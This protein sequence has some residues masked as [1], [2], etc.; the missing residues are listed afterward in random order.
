MTSFSTIKKRF[1]ELSS[2]DQEKL[3]KDIYSFSKDVRLFLE[4][5]LIGGTTIA[6][7]YTRQME[8]ETVGK[9]YRT[10]IPGVPNGKTVNAIITKAKK[11][12]VNIYTLMSIEQ[13][14]YRGFIEF[15]NEFGGG[16]ESFDDQACKH[17]EAYLK[18]L[19]DGQITTEERTKRYQELKNY[20]LAKDNIFTDSLDGVYESATGISIG[21]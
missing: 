14:A 2:G 7:E 18:L 20:L 12:H 21:R 4:N 3:L 13:L 19:Q 1:R 15:L 17:L 5:R 10:G 16:P 9:I 8:R 11:F 6:D